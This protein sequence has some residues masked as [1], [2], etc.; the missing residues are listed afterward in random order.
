MLKTI[1][2]TV[3]MVI[4]SVL[5]FLLKITGMKMHIVLGILALIITIVYTLL[6]K[7]DLKELSKKNIV[8]EILMRVCFAVALIT[9]FLL[10]PF[11]TFL[12]ISIIHKFAAIIF[13]VMLLV[14]NIRKIF[15]D[16]K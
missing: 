11:G 12:I 9:G 1:L 5:L 13:V 15:I 6:I 2:Y 8:M 4:I 7:K 14:I 3:F 10:K 16:K